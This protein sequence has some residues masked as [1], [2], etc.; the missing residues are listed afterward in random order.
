MRPSIVAGSGVH[1]H[2]VLKTEAYTKTPSM[3]TAIRVY[4]FRFEKCYYVLM[5]SPAANGCSQ[6]YKDTV[7]KA[8]VR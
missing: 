7:T 6:Y 5:V 3:H 4:F 8:G 2:D 1:D